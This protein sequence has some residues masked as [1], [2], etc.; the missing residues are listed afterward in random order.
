MFVGKA[1]RPLAEDLVKRMEESGGNGVM[2]WQRKKSD[3]GL[4]IKV[5]GKPSRS[6]VDMDGFQAISR[7]SKK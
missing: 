1:N 5:F 6:V 4:W 2:I 3:L 7:K